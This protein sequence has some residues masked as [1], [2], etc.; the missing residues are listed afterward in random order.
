MSLRTTKLLSKG[1]GARRVVPSNCQSESSIADSARVRVVV[2]ARPLL[3]SERKRGEESCVR[4]TSIGTDQTVCVSEELENSFGDQTS[5]DTEFKFDSCYDSSSAQEDI[6]NNEIAPYVPNALCGRN[7]TIFCYGMTGTGKTYTMSG[8]PDN[9]GIIPRAV[10]LLFRQIADT[11]SSKG[12]DFKVYASFLE[13]YNEKVYDLLVRNSHSKDLPVRE[14][15][16][17]QVIVANLSEHVIEDYS[18]FASLYRCGMRNRATASTSL[19][20]HSSRSHS[21]VVLKVAFSDPNVPRRRIIGKLHLIDLAGNEDNRATGNRG[22]RI[23][24]SSNINR[25]LFVLGQVIEA[26]NQKHGRIP[27]RDSKL[28]RLLQD[29][30]GGRNYAVMICNIA[31]SRRFTTFTL[32]TLAFANSGRQ[33]VNDP[34]TT[35]VEEPMPQSSL[36]SAASAS[37][38]AAAAASSSSSSS[39]VATSEALRLRLE[40]W[41][42]GKGREPTRKRKSSSLSSSSHRTAGA[43]HKRTHLE[44]E[45][46]SLAGTEPLLDLTALS[47]YVRKSKAAANADPNI[48]RRLEALASEVNALT[49]QL[50]AQQGRPQPAAPTQPLPL[51]PVSRTE[52]ARALVSTGKRYEQAGRV[53]DAI[54]SFESALLLMPESDK[55]RNKINSLKKNK[56]VATVATA[57]SALA[58]VNTNRMN[59]RRK[60]LSDNGKKPTVA[61]AKLNTK[62]LSKGKATLKHGPRG[63]KKQASSPSSPSEEDI[64]KR[65]QEEV[66]KSMQAVVESKLIEALNSYT[67]K[68]L[69]KLATI[70]AKRAEAIVD[71][72]EERMFTSLQDLERIGMSANMIA[73]FQ[74]KN[75]QGVFKLAV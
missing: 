2:R 61:T 27:Y 22:K 33:I 1:G 53:Q 74:D 10:R 25:S 70:G 56:T 12:V 44:Q 14:N 20:S 57:T 5:L 3:Q 24:E 23:I 63:H 7:T 67:E 21:M 26:L 30:L 18:S 58:P 28:T 73:K 52:Q 4:M 49:S 19:N 31:P 6:F 39:S 42:K 47:P 41:K 37:A 36:S 60:R 64:Q 75:S 55:L 11:P 35:I 8:T 40:Q 72:R 16:N 15:Y 69:K 45:S 34:S 17:G 46:S 66:C 71:E 38:S 54:Q 59:A 13:I 51:T 29:S 65:V 43:A 32:R 62:R 9:P 50:H 48:L 68:Q